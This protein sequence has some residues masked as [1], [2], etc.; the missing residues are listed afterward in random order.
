MKWF[1]NLPIQPKLC[2]S[3]AL[4]VALMGVALFFGLE[5]LNSAVADTGKVHDD[6]KTYSSLSSSRR[7]ASFSASKTADAVR[8]SLPEVAIKSASEAEAF[9]SLAFQGLTKYKDAQIGRAHV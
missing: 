2:L 9:D 1:N 6:E 7:D 8:A 5:A 4:T 3:F